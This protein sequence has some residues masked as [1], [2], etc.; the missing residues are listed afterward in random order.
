MREKIKKFFSDKFN[1]FATVLQSL[2]VLCLAFWVLSIVFNILFLL[3]ESVFFVAWGIKVLVDIKKIRSNFS[4]QE[5]LPYTPEQLNYLK[6]KH[7]SDIRNAKFK[8][9]MM[10]VLGVTF[11]YVTICAI[12]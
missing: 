8:G 11:I 12:I 7:L 3:L 10:I 9:S 4:L 6:K 1:I 5:K 2:A